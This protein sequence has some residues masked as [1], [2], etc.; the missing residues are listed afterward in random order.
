M[1]LR[2]DGEQMNDQDWSNP[3]TSSLGVFL[4]GRGLD[5]VDERG[6]LI[7]DDDLLILL[8]ASTTDLDFVLAPSN[9][10]DQPWEIVVDTVDDDAK[11]VTQPGTK[12][13]LGACS[14]KLFRRRIK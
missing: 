2:H 3:G 5:E 4:A 1:W 7:S 11:E 6:D 8:N 14:L 12:T 10:D 9:S 13:K